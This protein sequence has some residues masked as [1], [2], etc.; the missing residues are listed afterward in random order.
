MPQTNPRSAGREKQFDH[1]L[2][3]YSSAARTTL[4]LSEEKKRGGDG[5]AAVLSGASGATLVSAVGAVLLGGGN[6]AAVTTHTNGSIKYFQ[7]LNE[8]VTGW[9]FLNVDG[10]GA[11]DVYFYAQPGSVARVTDLS[12]AS[13]VRETAAANAV[14]FATGAEIKTTAGNKWA[15]AITTM[16]LN[17][18]FRPG[19]G[20]LGIKL[21]DSGGNFGWVYL[22]TFTATSF[23][24]A[25]YAYNTAGG[26][27]NAGQTETP[28]PE[29]STVALALLA[30]GAAGVMASRRKKL[31]KGRRDA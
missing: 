24:V 1:E 7:N 13:V 2:T 29:P 25:S 6:A 19:G 31:L 22:D 20:Y 21:G 9:F 23:R 8:V 14:N 26:S 30:S 16:D 12:L 10:V 28:V 3:E 11:N 27:I 18:N 15:G 17:N 5:R 4:T